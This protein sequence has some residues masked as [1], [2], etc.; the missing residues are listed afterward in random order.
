MLTGD[1][2]ESCMKAHGAE[3]GYAFDGDGDRLVVVDDTGRVYDGYDL[4]FVLARY[5]HERGRLRR[6]VAGILVSTVDTEEELYDSTVAWRDRAMDGV[7]HSG[8]TVR[9]SRSRNRTRL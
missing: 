8:K 7:F 2:P 5:Y 4:L 6:N 3:Y 9:D 1:R